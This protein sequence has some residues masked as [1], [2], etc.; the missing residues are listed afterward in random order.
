MAVWL[1]RKIERALDLFFARLVMQ[2]C[3]GLAR[4]SALLQPRIARAI[5]NIHHCVYRKPRF[6]SN[7]DEVH[8]GSGVNECF[9][10]DESDEKSAHPCAKT[11]AF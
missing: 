6:G 8:Q 10:S 2:T 1:K 4:P 11:D 5:A 3:V 7:G 9:R